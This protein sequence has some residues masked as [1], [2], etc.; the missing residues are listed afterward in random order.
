MH[1]I[2]RIEDAATIQFA[3]P[4]GQREM[5]FVAPDAPLLGSVVDAGDG[6]PGAFYAHQVARAPADLRCHVRRI[7]FHVAT[8][9]AEGGY[10]ALVDLFIALGPKGVALRSRMLDAAK[11]LLERTRYQ[12]LMRKLD[13]GLAATDSLSPSPC[14]RLT[15]G[16]RGIHLLVERLDR[17]APQFQ[18]DPLAEARACLEYGQVEQARRLLEDTVMA[19][20]WRADLHLE[21]LEIYR[22]TRDLD[23]FSATWALLDVASGPVADAWSETADYLERVAR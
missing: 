11:P 22:A 8:A 10:G 16:L 17:D 5:A 15:K 13:A 9:D 23:N 18:R 3:W 2:E 6:D 14:S 1:V 7:H 12:T 20:P 21:L 19:E 4:P